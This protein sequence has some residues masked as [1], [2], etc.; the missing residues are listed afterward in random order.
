MA[1]PRTPAPV[2]A[3]L[4][5]LTVGIALRTAHSFGLGGPELERLFLVW[6]YSG[7][8][9][10]CALLC[11]AR[12]VLVRRDRL[13][14][15]LTGGGTALWATGDVLYQVLYAHAELIPFPS[16]ADAAYYASYLFAYAGLVLLL[17]SR[18]RPWRAALWLDGLL[19][20]L[21]LAAVAAAL[22]VG[23]VVESSGGDLRTLSFS[24]VYAVADGVML[25]LAAL[26]FALT[27]WRPG[28]MWTLMGVS[29]LLTATADSVFTY[30]VA[31]G[32]YASDDVFGVLWLVAA[33]C[34][35]AAAWQPAGRRADD[36]GGLR[37]VVLP[38][39]SALVAIA[40]LVAAQVTPLPDYAVGLAAAA[41][42]AGVLRA[43][44]AFRENARL[45]RQADAQAHTD[46]LT[47]LGNRRRLLEDLDDLVDDAGGATLLFC[48][49]NGFK[50][51]ND[52]FGHGAGDAL[53]A[54]LGAA[55]ASAVSGTGRAYRLGGDEFCVLLDRVAGSD[56][57]AVRRAVGALAEHGDG[58]SVTTA[59][60]LVTLPAEAATAS[61]A[62]Q[63]ADE[64]MY[65]D[66][67]GRT[68]GRRQA[69]DVILQILRESAP[70]LR[71]H[72]D[73]VAS[74][75]VG[76]GRQLGMAPDVLDELARAAELHDVGKVALPAELLNQP[77]PL[78]PAE[79]VFVR[80]H[81]LVGERIL[82]AAPALRPAAVLVRSSHERWDGKG[83]PDGL[84]GDAVPLGARVIAACDAYWAMVAGRPYR[85]AV[86]A[87]AA[88][89]ELRRCAG[90]Q[91]D[92]DVVTALDAVVRHL[93]APTAAA[94]RVRASV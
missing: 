4:A 55:L 84:A 3:A 59:S 67:E 48:D 74:L 57:P 58:F 86:P 11:L 23:V 68:S 37:L 83:Y 40:L 76:V 8:M 36:A 89:R 14:W 26:A 41:L 50:S 69:R 12:G 71:E 77:G 75:A 56:D 30:R 31:V 20:G 32:A 66:K 64:R 29:L 45:L 79:W 49:L 16:V 1:P 25:C 78:T 54:R 34:L 93:D 53:L 65:A 24:M 2:R 27:A 6:V 15:L 7:V 81:T 94:G 35:A 92:P 51:Y 80:E 18:L 87:E 38:G 60:G 28:R 19:A 5:V 73:G 22:V 44:L 70:E 91:F 17:R 42:L 39:V 43:G 52:A 72:L 82:N 90:T 63:L 47:G 85:P 62:L 21:T 61:A 46:G 13:A 88:L 10:G 9:Y 33:L